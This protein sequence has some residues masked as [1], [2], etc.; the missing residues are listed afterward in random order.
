M[1]YNIFSITAQ[2]RP[3]FDGRTIIIKNILITGASRG[4][5]AS[6]AERFA[7]SGWNVGINYRVSGERAKE[8]AV[9]LSGLYGIKAVPY[10]A[11][12]SSS[13]QVKDMFA[14]FDKEIGE[15]DALVNNAGVSAS[16]LVQCVP[17]SEW[18]TVTDI[19]AGGVF[20]CC[21]CAAER[22]IKNKRGSIVNISSMWGQTGASCESFYSAS[23]GAV[24]AFTKALAK[25]LGP[26][27][28]RVNCVSPG[29]IDTD[30]NAS[31]S[32]ADI[33]ALAAE[34]PLCRIGKPE[35]VAEAVFFLISDAASFITGQELAVNGGFVI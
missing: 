3:F 30:M 10:C 31:Y 23:K 4:I 16:G 25:E 14:A 27:G 17:E 2:S 29:V 34:T 21:A 32:E 35:E 8:L 1:I 24:T 11:D 20:R 6:V 9:R 33:E 18:R 26:S 15:L 22:M 13:E 5:G 19:N 7:K 12:V 28:I